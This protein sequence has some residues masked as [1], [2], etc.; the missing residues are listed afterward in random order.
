M[1]LLVTRTLYFTNVKR[2]AYLHSEESGDYKM[3]FDEQIYVY[4]SENFFSVLIIQFMIKQNKN[5]SGDSYREHNDDATC[6]M[7]GSPTQGDKTSCGG[8]RGNSVSSQE[9]L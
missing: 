9:A 4:L 2:M 5:S 1:F 7:L 3:H 8:S 6:T